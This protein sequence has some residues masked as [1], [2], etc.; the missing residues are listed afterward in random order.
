MEFSV[1]I[2]INLLNMTH[3]NSTFLFLRCWIWSSSLWSMTNV[4]WGILVLVKLLKKSTVISAYCSFH[5]FWLKCF[6]NFF[7]PLF[8]LGFVILQIL[9]LH[10]V[11]FITNMEFLLGREWFEFNPWRAEDFYW[12]LS[13][14]SIVALFYPCHCFVHTVI[15][16]ASLHGKMCHA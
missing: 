7:L 14:F 13:V 15:L 6:S 12:F 1:C 11:L 3:F 8:L 16:M 10:S 5:M 4:C 2:Y 9:A